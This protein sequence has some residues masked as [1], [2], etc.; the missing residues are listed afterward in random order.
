M[1]VRWLAVLP[2]SHRGVGS[3]PPSTQGLVCMFSVCIQSFCAVLVNITI[4]V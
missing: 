1:V 4:G 3:N 2:R